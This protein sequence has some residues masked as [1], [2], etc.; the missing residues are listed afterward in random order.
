VGGSI[1]GLI[2]TVVLQDNGGD[3]LSVSA[4]GS[5]TFP[6][7]LAAGAAYA[8][9]V[10]VQPPGPDCVIT[11]ASGSA[12]GNV[13]SIVVTCA[14]NPSTVF[15]PMTASPVTGTTGGATGLFVVT[16]KA[17][18]RAPI[19]ITTGSAAA[20][21]FSLQ[22]SLSSAGILSEGNP[23]ALMYGT[24]GA[25]GGDHIW[26]LSLAGTSTLVPTQV[27]NLTVTGPIQNC[28]LFQGLKNLADPAS[29]FLILQ[30]AAV[31]GH[32]CSSSA[33]SYEYALIHLTDAPTAAPLLLPSL[34][35]DVVPLY[36]SS[37]LLGGLLNLDSSHNLN[38]YADETFTNPTLLLANVVSYAPFPASGLSPLVS[39]SSTP[40]F[41]FVIVQFLGGTASLYRVDYAG[42]L[43]ADLHDFQG[44]QYGGYGFAQDGNN[45]YFMDTAQT[46]T[47]LTQY[48]C[49]V[50]LSAVS[51]AQILYTYAAA[52]ATA[53]PYTLVGP[54]GNQLILARTLNT[55]PSTGQ[56]P[57]EIDALTIATP[58]TPVTIASFGD[59]LVNSMLSGGD[60][61]VG[62]VHVTS[63]GPGTFSYF[64]EIVSAD[65]T[66][67]QPLTSGSSFVTLATS[68]VLQIGD[69][70]NP[71]DFGGGSVSSIN[72]S[73]P[74][75]PVAMPLTPANGMSSALESGTT[76]PF[77]FSI[78]TTIG[79]GGA[80]G[81]TQDFA[82]AYD[83]SKGLIES[84]SMPNTNLRF[85]TAPL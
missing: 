77:A 50:P 2:G 21:G 52:V 60:L 24:T 48:I 26:A 66:V 33:S 18:D 79:I 80:D 64:T 22:F 56:R 51:S 37:G 13:T 35:G 10:S 41:S 58:A 19:P 40:T 23:Y 57:S 47:T 65:G 45:F 84:I 70:T 62:T 55:D 69:I 54:T 59:Y 28:V 72:V 7:R 83:L 76:F 63:P 30:L 16:S 34:N 85:M 68:P 75:A 49:Q 36:Q 78:S 61:F 67:L 29:E 20:L 3:T 27:S 53:T 4:N 71:D 17:F 43:S 15:L 31:A 81:A 12:S 32:E 42:R 1:S 74:S 38:F 6:T 8:V 11:G 73:V 5:F 39:V 82:L 25:A 44:G 9:T 46:S 14:V